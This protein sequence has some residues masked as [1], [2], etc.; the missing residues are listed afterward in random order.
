MQIVVCQGPRGRGLSISPDSAAT[1]DRQP[2][3][4]ADPNRK[5]AMPPMPEP[6][7]SVAFA[8]AIVISTTS[9]ELQEHLLQRWQ[10][11]VPQAHGM[12]HGV[13]SIGNGCN[14]VFLH[15][16][17]GLR[18]VHNMCMG[19]HSCRLQT[20]CCYAVCVR[21]VAGEQRRGNAC[22]TSDTLEGLEQPTCHAVRDGA[23]A[24]QP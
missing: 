17:W 15:G 20:P 14:C 3:E 2:D 22:G 13:R 16:T 7:I 18:P 11:R 4:Q 24:P 19:A 5:Q 10:V 12:G 9:A 23:N 6:S 21:A 8:D 1:A